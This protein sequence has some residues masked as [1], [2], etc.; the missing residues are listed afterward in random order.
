[1]K[2]HGIKNF[3]TL[4]V[5]ALFPTSCISC[6]IKTNEDKVLCEN[7]EE[8]IEINTSFFCP[9][10]SKRLLEIKNECHPETRYILGSACS[11]RNKTVRDLIHALK[12]DR[13]A[14]AA[15]IL[16]KILSLYIEH[17][18][19]RYPE[20]KAND[21]VIFPMPLHRKKERK[22]GF[23]QSSLIL[24]SL[25]KLILEQNKNTFLFCSSL[26]IIKRKKNTPSQTKCKSKKERIAH[27][28][29]AFEIISPEKIADKN[30]IILDDVFTSGA[31]MNEAVRAVKN[32]GARKVIALVIAKT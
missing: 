29:D 18:T 24:K 17:I 28:E 20:F 6:G 5:G 3:F 16:A 14:R 9:N 7:C 21:F 12:Y 30:V 27:M 19:V 1:M 4:L 13:V 8:K 22:R 25:N 15:E 31:T 2:T 11:Y 23:N 10:C 32:A 26:G